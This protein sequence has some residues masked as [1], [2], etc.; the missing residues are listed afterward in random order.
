M[1]AL[2]VLKNNNSQ[3]PDRL[4]IKK[5]NNMIAL[6]VLKWDQVTINNI[7]THAVLK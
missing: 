7:I 1:I 3:Q 2:M 5:N 6:T 4:M